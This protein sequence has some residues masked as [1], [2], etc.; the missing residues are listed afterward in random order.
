MYV[1]DS[2]IRITHVEFEGRA[3]VLG[4]FVDDDGDGDSRDVDN[5][6]EDPFTPDGNDCVGHGT[7]V[8]AT[9]GGASAG[10]AKNALIWGLR[11]IGCNGF[12]TWSAVVAAIDTVTADAR[13]PAV[14]N[15]SLSGTPS[16][17]ADMAIER[18]IASGI[19]YVVA[20]G[21]EGMDA[22]DSSP[23]RVMSALVVASTGVDDA[24]SLI[25]NWG[26]AIDLF[27]PGE[28]I[29]SAG[30]ENDTDLVSASGT[31]AAAA[32]ATG[33]A[34]L[35]LGARPSARPSAV[36]SALVSAATAGVVT[37]GTGSANRLLYCG[38]SD[39]SRSSVTYPNTRVNWGR[40]SRQLITW[41][42]SLPVNS[43]VRILL[44]RD[45]ARSFEPIAHNSAATSPT[46]E[47]SRRWSRV[48]IRP[49]RACASRPS[50]EAHSMTLMRRS[51]LPIRSFA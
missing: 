39:A 24:R 6:D 19:L 49:R 33:V 1:I 25:S 3:F 15:L 16:S 26:P 8:A 30:I 4:D 11:V 5:D 22:S 38:Y 36:H 48:R 18:S 44:S 50:M 28:E 31:S 14:V 35:Y 47:A 32:H 29:V 12:G 45:D 41:T 20:A 27:A 51:S 17:I 40:G 9:I 10:V 2:G 42:H 23:S 7:H 34:A 21:N 13:R 43:S 37:D 46:V